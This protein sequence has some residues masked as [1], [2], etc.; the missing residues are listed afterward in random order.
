LRQFSYYQNQHLHQFHPTQN[1]DLQPFP[2]T[3]IKDLYHFPKTKNNN[4]QLSQLAWADQIPPK[5]HPLFTMFCSTFLVFYLCFIAKP[6]CF[7]ILCSTFTNSSQSSYFAIFRKDI[8]V[9]KKY[10]IPLSAFSPSRYFFLPKPPFL[11]YTTM[12]VETNEIN[13]M[14]LAT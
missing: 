14:P 6:S 3:K 11:R 5:N 8:T 4:L 7:V 10:A 12:Y 2:T 13:G 9:P 1:K